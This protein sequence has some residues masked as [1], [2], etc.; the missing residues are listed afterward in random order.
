MI[1]DPFQLFNTANAVLDPNTGKSL[2]NQKLI[3]HPDPHICQTWQRSSANELGRLTQAVG[4]H[5]TGTDTIWFIHQHEVPNGRTATYAHFVCDVRDQKSEPERTRVT[6][7]GDLIDY[8][9]PSTTRTCDLVT[10]KM[11]VN[12]TLPRHRCKY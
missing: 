2:E 8:P 1:E 6:V 7:G 5:I 12:C 10:F 9:D 11:H 3:N 4:N